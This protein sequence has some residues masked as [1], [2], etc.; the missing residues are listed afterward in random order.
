M[1][2]ER[3]RADDPE[4]AGRQKEATELIAAAQAADGCLN[5]YYQVHPELGRIEMAL[6][7]LYRLTG[8][9]RY[10]YLARYFVTA[11]TA[12]AAPRSPA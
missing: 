4:L 6:T 3:G 1:A 10:L 7:E 2:W 12:R 8:E 5:S 11:P 9:A